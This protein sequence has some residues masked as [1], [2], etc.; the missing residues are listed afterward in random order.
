MPSTAMVNDCV[1]IVVE[2]IYLF[3]YLDPKQFR[4]TVLWLEDQKIRHYK[5]EERAGLR[6]LEAETEWDVAFEAF[7]KSVGVPE[8]LKSRTEELAWLLAY[9]TRLEYYDNCE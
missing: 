2:E 3:C 7:K 5:I 9:A 8:Y 4:A 1:F 6:M